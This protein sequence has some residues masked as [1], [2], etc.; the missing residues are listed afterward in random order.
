[1]KYIIG[2]GNKGKEYEYTRHNVG[3]LMVEHIQDKYN[4][5][6][7]KYNKYF[8]ADIA[9]GEIDGV[10]YTLVKPTTFMNLSGNT[11]A[12]ILKHG[13]H[14]EDLIVIH[15]ELAYPFGT[16][17]LAQE[18]SDAGHNGVASIIQV[19]PNFLRLRVGIHSYKP[20]TDELIELKN[21]VRADFVLKEFRPDE[22]NKIGGIGDIIIGILKSLEK[23]GVE[24]TMTEVNKRK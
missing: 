18:K 10:S 5:S 4:F 2:L 8:S 13:A 22:K 14:K 23:D 15:D 6:D 1:M 21:E 12:G 16:L 11:V 9:E 17:R 7:W 24:K 20:E 19:I 3:F